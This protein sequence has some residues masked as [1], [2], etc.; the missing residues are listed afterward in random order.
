MLKV[1]YL[2]MLQEKGI[3]IDLI[4]IGA[5]TTTACLMIDVWNTYNS[6]VGIVKHPIKETCLNTG[7]SRNYVHK[8]LREAREILQIDK[9][10]Y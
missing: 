4:K 1:E 3:L 2:K 9:T 7:I 5:C 8:L 6:Y 10:K